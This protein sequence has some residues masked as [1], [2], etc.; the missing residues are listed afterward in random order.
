MEVFVDF[1]L[2][3]LLAVIGLGMLSRAIYSRRIVGIV[4]LLVSAAAPLVM[5]EMVSG[6]RLRWISAVSAATALVNVAVVAAVMQEGRIPRLRLE[7]RRRGVA[8]SH[9]ETVQPVTRDPRIPDL[10]REEEPVAMARTG[11]T[12]A[13]A[14]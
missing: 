14:R 6:P 2:F 3:E 12:R 7:R 1:G 8:L 4:F 10:T 5:L 9:P 13:S 11:K